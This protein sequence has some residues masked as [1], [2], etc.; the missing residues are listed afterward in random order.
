MPIY[1]LLFSDCTVSFTKGQ[2]YKESVHCLA[3]PFIYQ[4]SYCIILD[5]GDFCMFAFVT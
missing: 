1:T 4:T 3:A 5:V 2:V